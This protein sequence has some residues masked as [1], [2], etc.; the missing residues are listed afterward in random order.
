MIIWVQEG[1]KLYLQILWVYCCY[2][3]LEKTLIL[4]QLPFF[5]FIDCLFIDRLSCYIHIAQACLCSLG[6]LPI[7]GPSASTSW[8]LGLQM[9]ATTPLEHRYPK[10]FKITMSK[11]HLYSRVLWDITCSRHNGVFLKQVIIIVCELF[12]C[13][14]EHVHAMD[15]T[16]RGSQRETTGTWFSPLPF[17][18]KISFIF[19]ELRVLHAKWPVSFWLTLLCLPCILP[20][21]Y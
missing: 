7:C 5:T 16:E 9:H 11:T 18:G 15:S 21:Q 13:M 6:R 14:C 17:R 2:L 3:V 4:P 8:V 20:S 19:D 10:E 1:Q 12:A